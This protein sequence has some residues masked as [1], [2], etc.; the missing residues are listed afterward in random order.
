MSNLLLVRNLRESA[1]DSEVR[2]L[3]RARTLTALRRLD[4]SRKDELLQFLVKADL[5]QSVEGRPPLITLSSA[6][7]SDTGLSEANLSSADLSQ[8]N[9]SDANLSKANLSDADLSDA[10]LNPDGSER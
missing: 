6:D 4:P 9:L 5:V 1:M 10:D 2:T 7:L 3:A 8:A